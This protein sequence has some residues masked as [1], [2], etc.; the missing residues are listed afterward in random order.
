MWTERVHGHT[1]RDKIKHGL[2]WVTAS[3]ADDNKGRILMCS[4][5]GKD[6]V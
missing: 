3:L 2:E 6:E 1:S 5:V 4:V